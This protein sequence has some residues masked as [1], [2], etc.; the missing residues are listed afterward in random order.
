MI[1]SELKQVNHRDMR[2]IRNFSIPRF[3]F[4]FSNVRF[5]S[6]KKS[7]Y[8]QNRKKQKLS[9]KIVNCSNFSEKEEIVAKWKRFLILRS[10]SSHWGEV[11][12]VVLGVSRQKI[13]GMIEIEIKINCD[14]VLCEQL[15]LICKFSRRFF[16]FFL[17]KNRSRIIR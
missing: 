9:T 6:Q 10:Q 2:K 13:L 5:I 14:W 15:R 12:K 11:R 3:A 8:D 4:F 17:W 16:F 7:N 1:N